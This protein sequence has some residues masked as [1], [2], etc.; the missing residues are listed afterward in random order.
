MR[1]L[2]II[3]ILFLSIENEAQ[4][5]HEV[6]AGGG[7]SSGVTPFYSPQFL[8][9]NQGDTVRWINTQGTHNVDGSLDTYPGNPVGFYSG[10]PSQG[11]VFE[12]VFDIAGTYGFECSQGDHAQ[13]QFGIIMV[14]APNSIEE[15][16]LSNTTIYPNPSSGLITLSS[17]KK[18]KQVRV[19]NAI[20]ELIYQQ[21]L[22]GNFDDLQIDLSS[23]S[24]GIYHIIFIAEDQN[25]F[26]KL[27]L[28]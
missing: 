8:T 17:L 1:S 2:L 22:A 5:S 25:S 10:D 3:F 21:D 20:G 19:L 18:V 16:G 14:I 11:W 4:V 13:T 28:N 15:T 24:Q 23:H 6:I 12:F 7:G 27:I 26:K 9:I